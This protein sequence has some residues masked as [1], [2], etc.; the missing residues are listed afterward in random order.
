MNTQKE[1]LID[2]DILADHLSAL[3]EDESDLELALQAGI[4]FTT[5]I[6][7]SELFYSV[8]NLKEKDI[9]YNLLKSLKILGIHSRYSISVPEFSDKTETARDALLCATAKINKLPILTNNV[10]KYVKSG[11]PV[12]H[13]KELRS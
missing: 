6:N 11:L 12:I 9:I 2:T 13:P 1:F 4:C 3:R 5:V 8:A 10:S 7:A